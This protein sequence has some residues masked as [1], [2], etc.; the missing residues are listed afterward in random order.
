MAGVWTA[1]DQPWSQWA[2]KELSS[3]RDKSATIL[4]SDIYHPQ[5]GQMET[6]PK[7]SISSGTA[8]QT[9]YFLFCSPT[10]RLDFALLCFLSP[11]PW[12]GVGLSGYSDEVGF[13]H[14]W[15]MGGTLGR[16]GECHSNAIQIRALPLKKSGF[17]THE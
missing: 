8:E 15:P 10:K 13:L 3:G 12:Q 7:F 4:C 14:F 9:A 6:K 1:N 5:N 2:W 16:W 17:C 11:P